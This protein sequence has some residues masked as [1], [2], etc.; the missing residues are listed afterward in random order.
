MS[1]KQRTRKQAVSISGVG[2]HTG[3]KLTL[4]FNPAPENHWYKFQRVDLD[5][6]PTID[7][8]ADLVVDTSRGTTLEQN[9]ARVH[10][11]E[12]VLAALVGLKID[13]CLI[14]VTGP[15]MPIMDGSSIKFMELLEQAGIVEQT[16]ERDYFVLTQNLSY[17]DSVK[18]VEMLA[19]PQ[20]DFRVTVM[21]D[22]GSEVLGT[23]HASMYKIDDFKTEIAP[24]RTFVF[25]RELEALLANNLIKGGDLDNAI[26]LVDSDLPEEKLNHLRKVFNKPNVQVKGRGVL[27]NTKLH[28]YNEPARHKLLDIVGDLALI[29]KPLKI[30]VLAARPGHAGNIDFAKKIKQMIREESMKKKKNIYVPYDL[31]KTPLYDI[32]Q[33]QKII[34]H[35]QPFLF[36]DKIME[37]TEEGIVGVKNV[38]MNE[39]F[40][41]GHFPGAPVFPGV[42]QIEAMAQVGGIFSLSKVPDPENY[43]TFFMSLDKVKFKNK[44]IP[45]DTIVFKLSL[46]TPI[47]RGIVHMKGEAFVREKLVMEAE[48]MALLSKVK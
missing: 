44:V 12:H 8:D 15:E 10:T 5:N 3:E 34:P 21:V 6:K 39:E 22:Y 28:F 7:A 45:G 37:I 18:K 20:D 11:T 14:Q 38:S 32:N 33:I 40:F 23:Q 25:L 13:N 19:V 47:R 48:M 9:G 4:T 17:E 43:L 26:V 30:H 16:A 35:R 36:V 27:N 46:I 31:N 41:K 42:L 2:L 29:G 24:C 1:D